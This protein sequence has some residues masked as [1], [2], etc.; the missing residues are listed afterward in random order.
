MLVGARPPLVAFNVELAAPATIDDARAIAAAIREGGPEGLPGVR[1]LGLELPARAGVAQVSTNVEDHLAV[2]LAQLVEAVARHA[3]V[4][5]LRARR[6]RA[7]GRVRG[8]PTASRCATGAR[9]RTL[10]SPDD[11]APAQGEKN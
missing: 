5:A 11:G 4:A 6:P 9:S 8:F 1:A 7:G 2:P 3:D 10:S